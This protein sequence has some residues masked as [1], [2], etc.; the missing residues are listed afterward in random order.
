MVILFLI[1]SL[2]LCAC[3]QANVT[4]TGET[5]EFTDSTGRTVTLPANIT[6]IAI[7]GPLS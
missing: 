6:K 7:S 3:G 5:Q 4:P 1:L 2:L